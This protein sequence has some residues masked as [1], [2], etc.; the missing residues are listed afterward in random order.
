MTCFLYH[1]SSSHPPNQRATNSTTRYH[2]TFPD[3]LTEQMNEG[4]ERLSAHFEFQP[5]EMALGVHIGLAGFNVT[6]RT[7]DRNFDVQLD[8]GLQLITA[9]QT[10]APKIYYNEHVCNNT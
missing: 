10:A 9:N 6:L 1:C 2:Q 4:S 3:L 5:Y 8:G 7:I